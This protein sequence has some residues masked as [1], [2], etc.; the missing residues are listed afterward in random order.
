M[1]NTTN[2]N[3]ATPADTDLVKDGAAAIRTLGNSIDTS[4]VDLKGGTTGQVLTKAS[5][6]DLDFNFTTPLS[7]PLTTTG[8]II[9]SSSGSTLARLGIGTTGQV[10]TVNSGATAPQW[11]AVNAG[12][13]TLLST[14]TMSGSST[15]VSSISQSYYRLFIEFI[16]VQLATTGTSIDIYLDNA[17]IASYTGTKNST[18]FNENNDY[19][20]L[21]D[22]SAGSLNTQMNWSL[23]VDNYTSTANYKPFLLYGLGV[24]GGTDFKV[25]MGGVSRSN[26]AFDQVNIRADNG[27]SPLTG[28]IKVWGIK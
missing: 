5:G 28:T 18:I 2:F 24:V 25:L 15:T 20:K 14:T 16:N 21:T 19:V 8:D 9:Y 12:G 26:A 22:R 10:L 23:T 3:W 17:I 27:T 1:P 13:M 11:A 7:N 6:T 4:L